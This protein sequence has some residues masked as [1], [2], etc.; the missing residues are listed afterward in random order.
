[1]QLRTDPFEGGAVRSGCELWQR[2][3]GRGVCPSRPRVRRDRAL[4]RAHS[5][6]IS[7]FS[8]RSAVNGLRGGSAHLH[9]EEPATI[10]APTSLTRPPP[11]PHLGRV[12]FTC[13][14]TLGSPRSAAIGTCSPCSAHSHQREQARPPGPTIGLEVGTRETGGTIM[15]HF[16]RGAPISR[17]PWIRLS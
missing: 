16:D 10:P 7:Q 11:Q 1:M 13:R 14:R 15:L 17:T 12:T 9:S 8:R 5:S 2:Q 3:P 6:L 4:A